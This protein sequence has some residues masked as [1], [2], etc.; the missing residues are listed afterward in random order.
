MEVSNRCSKFLG[1]EMNNQNGVVTAAPQ[2]SRW[3]SMKQIVKMR[4]ALIYRVSKES[5]PDC[6]HLLQENYVEYIFLM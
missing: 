6:K 5:F 4:I 2:R 3:T 1:R